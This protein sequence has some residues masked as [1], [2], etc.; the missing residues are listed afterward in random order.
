MREESK[1]KLSKNV[2]LDGNEEERKRKGKRKR[3]K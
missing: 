1:L 2:K 3:C